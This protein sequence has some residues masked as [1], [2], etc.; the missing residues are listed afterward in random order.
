MKSNRGVLALAL[1]GAFGILAAL[2]SFLSA[3]P[4]F[5]WNFSASAPTGLYRMLVRPA[6]KGDWVALNPPSHIR[7]LLSEVRRSSG[8]RFLIK[9]MAAIEGD[10]VCRHDDTVT[11]NGVVAAKAVGRHVG[12][13]ALPVWQ[14]CQTLIANE[15]FFLGEAER[16]FDSRYFGPLETSSLIGPL[17][18]LDFH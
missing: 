6:R 15:A 18:K 10:V 13:F 12:E 8:S 17:V 14:G 9:R 11:I 3:K 1:S 4:V 5:V 7:A 16:S 2:A